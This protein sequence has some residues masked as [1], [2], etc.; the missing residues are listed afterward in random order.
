MHHRQLGLCAVRTTTCICRVIIMSPLFQAVMCLR[1]FGA[2]LRDGTGVDG[3]CRIGSSST[4]RCP[5]L[6]VLCKSKLEGPCNCDNCD[7]AVWDGMC[8]PSHRS[9]QSLVDLGQTGRWGAQCALG[10]LS[11]VA[12]ECL[13]DYQEPCWPAGAYLS[14]KKPHK[15]SPPQGLG[16]RQKGLFAHTMACLRLSRPK[17]PNVTV[18]GACTPSVV[19][20]TQL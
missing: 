6:V 12:T 1:M 3:T 8:S 10:I 17:Y 15:P 14:P 4:G 19:D 20:P 16:R 11:L 7:G 9:S 18:C 2:R 13:G 5:A